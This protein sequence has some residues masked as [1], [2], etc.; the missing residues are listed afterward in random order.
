MLGTRM[1][2]GIYAGTK[3]GVISCYYTI[4]NFPVWYK[5]QIQELKNYFANIKY[6]L[7]HLQE[8]NLE[9]GVYH[10]HKGNIND[11]IIRFTLIDKFIAP[12][13]QLANYWLGW[14][15]FLKNNC[16][17]A[18]YHLQR[19][20]DRDVVKLG[21]F[22]ENYQD[23]MEIPPEIW[24]QY[25]EL[26][27]EY[28]PNNFCSNTLNLPYSFIQETIDKIVELPDNYN[29]LELN[30]NIGLAGYEIRKRFPDSFNLIGTESSS[31]MNELVNL[32]YPNSKIYDQFFNSSVRDFLD[33]T[34]I[35]VDVILSF[36]GLSFTKDLKYYFGAIYNILNNNG[37][38]S[39]C[40]PID[41]KTE[42]LLKRTE[43]V[44]NPNEVKEALDSS[45]F[46]I[47]GIKELSLG[48]NNKYN[49]YAVFTCRKLVK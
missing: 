43:Y 48:T 44:F 30:S 11:A 37:Y 4:K 46:T 31:V 41:K 39:F 33:N 1:I 27:A 18:I 16:K 28:Y 49:K 45:K 7:S 29:I 40:L 26:T 32:Y 10:L 15:Y 25:R 22:L 9:L 5:S 20:S 21:S 13:D 14:C 24:R 47:L 19:A 17:K 3:K 35:K 12:A 23:Y 2:Y 6:R 8:T 34:S 42:L 36:C 38:L